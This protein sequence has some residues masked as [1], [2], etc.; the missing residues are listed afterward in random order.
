MIIEQEEPSVPS[1]GWAEMIRKV[2]EID[3]LICPKCGGQMPACASPLSYR[4]NGTGREA[5]RKVISFIEDHRVIDKI[6]N[7]FKLIFKAERSPPP[8]AQLIW[9]LRIY[10]NI[11]K[12][13]VLNQRLKVNSTLYA[14]FI[15][16]IL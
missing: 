11:Y 4:A 10:Q 7:H 13:K 12:R 2:Y 3:P 6:I 15:R 1:K 8:K 14:L 5:D 16:L 9:Q